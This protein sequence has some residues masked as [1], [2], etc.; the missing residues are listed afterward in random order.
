[1][2]EACWKQ[3][4]KRIIRNWGGTSIF[5][6]LGPKTLTQNLLKQKSRHNKVAM[7][8]RDCKKRIDKRILKLQRYSENSKYV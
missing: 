7:S 3:T 2:V 1:M 8:L 5:G 6:H 4:D